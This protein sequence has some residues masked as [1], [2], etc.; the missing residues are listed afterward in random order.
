M[1][2][3]TSLTMGADTRKEKVTPS[4]MPT[5]MKPMKRGTAEHE[6]KGVTIPSRAARM[7]PRNSGTF[8]SARLVFSGGKKISQERYGENDDDQEKEDL[9]RVVDEEIH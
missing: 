1:T 6:Q 5:S 3:A 7:F 2:S 4:G 8:S 9:R